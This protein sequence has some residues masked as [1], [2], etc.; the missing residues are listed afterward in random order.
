MEICKVLSTTLIG[1][2]QKKI[3]TVRRGSGSF[4]FLSSLSGKSLGR[5]YNHIGK[6]DKLLNT[7]TDTNHLHLEMLPETEEPHGTGQQ[8]LS[9]LPHRGTTIPL[10]VTQRGRHLSVK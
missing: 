3:P 4:V 7:V 5:E 1:S 8:L 2:Y 6:I 9:G 10:V